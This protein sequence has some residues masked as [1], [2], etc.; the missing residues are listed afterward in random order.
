MEKNADNNLDTIENKK[1]NGKFNEN[2][3]Y[4]DYD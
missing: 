2:G 3:Y 4:F 1:E